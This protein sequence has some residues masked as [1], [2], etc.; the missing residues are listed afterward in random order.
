MSIWPKQ[1]E[2]SSYMFGLEV[3]A[4]PVLSTV[5]QKFL[6]RLTAASLTDCDLLNHT[7]E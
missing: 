1:I 7:A 2:L 3:T 4:V 5:K 6:I